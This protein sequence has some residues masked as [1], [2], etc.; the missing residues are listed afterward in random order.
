MY[1][2]F[3]SV[4]I[5]VY[6]GSNYLEEA[7]NS[8]LRQ[9]Y[10][11]REI[12]VVDDGSCDK[13]KTKEIIKLYKGKVRSFYKENG[14]VA[15]ALNLAI[16]NMRGDYFAWLSH[17]DLLKSNALEV[18][19][20]YLQQIEPETI[21]YG[22][23][24]LIDERSEPYDFVNF[25]NIFTREELEWSVY[26]VITG[27]VNGCACLIHKCHFI[28]VGFFN[29]NLKVTQ[30]NEMWFRIFRGQKVKF[31]EQFL[32]S[33]RYHKQQDS[34]VKNVFPD[35]DKFL[36]DSLNDLTIWEKSSVNGN[37]SRFY[38]RFYKISKDGKHPLMEEHCKNMLEKAKK[39]ETY[40]DLNEGELR[41]LLAKSNEAYQKLEQEYRRLQEKYV[42][43]WMR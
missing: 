40:K 9:S 6:N 38:L 7:L 29:E 16:R 25:L 17:D 42:R 26:P 19:V 24:D 4:V 22:N 32:C 3:I 5:P 31:I 39:A 33:K 37:L 10:T 23:Y 41:Q 30:D 12:I 18:Y 21:L 35:E 15:T 8:A 36:Y 13:G 28:R 20:N 11:K 43:Q 27:C 34:A 14:G 1:E 2:P